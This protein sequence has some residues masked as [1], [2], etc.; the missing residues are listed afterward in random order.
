VLAVLTGLVPVLAG[1]SAA[2]AATRTSAGSKV[3]AAKTPYPAT[4]YFSLGKTK[5]EWT[6]V[7]PQ[8]EPFYASGIDHVTSSEDVDQVTGQCP[9]CETIASEYP[10]TSAWDAATIPRLRSWGFNTLG[11]Y[12][13]DTN[14]GASMPYEVQLSMASGDDWFA[15]SFV[16]NADEVAATQVAPLANDPNVIGYFTDSELQLGGD[17]ND[18]NPLIDEYLALPAG[19]PGLAVAQQYIGNPEGFIYALMT[20]YFS[21]TTA[22]VRMY[23]THHLILGVKAEAQEIPPQLLEAAAPYVDVFSIDDYNLAPTLAQAVDEIWPQYLPVEPNFANFEQYVNRP[24]MVG[25]YSFRA[26]TDQTPNTQPIVLATYPDQAT[27]ANAYENYAAP[28]LLDS[29]WVVGDDWFEY[30]DEPA[31]GRVGDGENN[32]YGLVD[33]EDQPY[34]DMV[35]ALQLLHSVAPDH[36]AQSGPMC[37][38]WADSSGGVTCTAYLDPATYPLTI[39]TDSLTNVQQG[40]AFNG[41]GANYNGYGGVY[42]A[43]GTP[44]Y[45]F[46]VVS[47]ALPKGLKMKSTTGVI[48]GTPKV[49]GAFDF[50]VEVRDSKGATATQALSMTVTP[51]VPL[52]VKTAK[53][54][55]ASE[56]APYT[57]TLAATGGTAPYTWAVTGGALPAGLTLGS[58]GQFSGQPAAA[59]TFTFTVQVTD[60]T[61]PAETASKSLGLVIKPAG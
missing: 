22:A 39:V 31:G 4:G 33:V 25:E 27:R 12:S 57:P 18:F 49:P 2:S 13:D 32:N 38:S 15:P 35:S 59:G 11:P 3:K 8:G 1:Q 24:I 52:S 14:L 17:G 23:D 42:A 50:T 10:S 58:N 43:G 46:T 55:K 29:P 19:S 6:L 36:L 61:V 48:T 40:T 20:R 21:V 53:L 9:Y 7:T 45:K 28:L 47:G 5:A 60:S 51:D 41:D 44:A 26:T 54:T 37:D 56:N 34:Q 16:T 30:V